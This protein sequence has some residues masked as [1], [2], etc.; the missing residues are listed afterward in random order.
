[1]SGSAKQFR[2]NGKTGSGKSTLMRYIYEDPRTLKALQVWARKR[3]IEVFTPK[4]FFWNPGSDLQKSFVGMLRSFL[5]QIL[6][7]NPAPILS[8]IK[9]GPIQTWTESSLLKVLRDLLAQQLTSHRMCFFLDGLDEASSDHDALISFSRELARGGTHK[10]V[11]SSRPYPKFEIAFASC[12]TLRL[13][14]LTHADIKKFT[15]DRFFAHPNGH[16]I[17]HDNKDIWPGSKFSDFINEIA[18]SSNGVFLWVVIAVK[19]QMDGLDN[20]DNLKQ[21]KERLKTL[22]TELEDLYETLLSRIKKVNREEAAVYLGLSLRSHEPFKTLLDFTLAANSSLDNMLESK[23]NFPWKGV[24]DRC[25]WTRKRVSAIC[26]GLLE[27]QDYDD[28]ERPLLELNL[29]E[30]GFMITQQNIPE[31][32]F[33]HRT[34]IDYFQES[35]LARDFIRENNSNNCH[36]SL[37]ETKV[38]LAKVRMLGFGRRPSIHSKVAIPIFIEHLMLLVSCTEYVSGVAQM[39]IH[40]YVDRAVSCIEP[41][42]VQRPQESHWCAKIYEWASRDTWL[43]SECDDPHLVS[44]VEGY[45]YNSTGQHMEKRDNS[46]LMPGQPV[47]Y[48]GLAVSFGLKLFVQQQI[49]CMPSGLPK[50]VADYLLHCALG[51][52]D[53]YTESLTPRIFDIAYTLLRLGANP[54]SPSSKGIAWA[55]SL[56]RMHLAKHS[57]PENRLQ[58]EINEG[59][60]M[61]YVGVFRTTFQHFLDS[62]ADIS[63]IL[64][65][66]AFRFTHE[67][68]ID[69]NHSQALPATRLR[70]HREGQFYQACT[71]EIDIEM[72]VPTLIRYCLGFSIESKKLASNCVDRGARFHSKCVS[73]ATSVVPKMPKMPREKVTDRK[74]RALTDQESDRFIKAYE[75]IVMPMRKPALSDKYEIECVVLAIHYE[76]SDWTTNM[77]FETEPEFETTESDLDEKDTESDLESDAIQPSES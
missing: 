15:M 42:E 65:L 10:V 61:S 18:E 63:G 6:R 23:Q 26:A 51:F 5:Y 73:V 76:L 13:Q 21:L 16:T 55:T 7:S 32:R 47:D 37:L 75:K 27:V 22:P 71:Y 30:P 60:K 45:T 72:S 70:H 67:F 43:F 58:M 57:W 8:Q 12:A 53:F 59:D 46:N 31:V 11:L 69:S 44:V 17:N 68:R 3:N 54:N 1:M 4:F 48:L 74:I 39:A 33:L 14:D 41:K 66:K 64:H 25:T 28:L 62:G 2:I 29:Q 50:S 36:S 34:V 49:S 40:K 24:V 20:E 77:R 56:N 9:K 52:D 38:L 35:S 19:D